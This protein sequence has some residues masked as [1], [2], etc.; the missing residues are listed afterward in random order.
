MQI[1]KTKFAGVWEIYQ[2]RFKDKRGYFFESFNK[3]KFNKL[4]K[5]NYNF[6]QDNISLSKKMVFRGFHLQTKPFEQ[7]KIVQVLSGEI[8]DIILDL[9]K[10]SKTFGKIIKIYLSEK[11]NKQ[12]FIP[13]GLAHGF[14]SLKDNTKILY[15]TSNFYSKKNEVTI[16][17]NDPNINL[18]LNKKLILSKK[19][20]NG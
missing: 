6:V 19:A 11:N 13:E 7:A 2:N 3:K 1:K 5:K 10:N 16:C 15:K 8:L 20:K 12:I 4:V 18:D 17:Y 9:R 14:L